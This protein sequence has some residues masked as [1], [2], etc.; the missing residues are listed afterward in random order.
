MRYVMIAFVAMVAFAGCGGGTDGA[1]SAQP[2]APVDPGPGAG[3][4]ADG[5]LSIADAKASDLEGPLMVG[6]F[7][8]AEDQV[9]RLCDTLME[10]LPPQ[11]GGE[12]L[13]VEGLDLD[14]YETRSEGE[15]RWTD[16]PVSVLGD[17]EG[18]TLRVRDTAA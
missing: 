2:D 13:L 16:A 12:S 15:V 18:E 11:C 7:L 17:V 4:P 10:S 8:V 9:V 5:G 14:T 3:A 6:G 1:P